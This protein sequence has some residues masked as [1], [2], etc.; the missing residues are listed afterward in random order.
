MWFDA[1]APARQN[2]AMDEKPKRRWFQFSLPSQ[3]ALVTLVAVW[4]GL[5][6]NRVTARREW[7]RQNHDFI[8]AGGMGCPRPARIMPWRVWLGDKPVNRVLISRHWNSESIAE[9]K[10]LFPEAAFVTRRELW[11]REISPDGYPV[12]LPD[13]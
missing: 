8:T 2:R 7:I 4:I 10:G 13:D 11:G 12:V 9:A 5:E 6:T 3:L 1:A